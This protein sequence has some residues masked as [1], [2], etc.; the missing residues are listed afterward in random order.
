MKKQW[1]IPAVFALGLLGAACGG[2]GGGGSATANP[3]ASPAGEAA[4]GG[5]ASLSIQGFAFHPDTL[6]A[7]AGASLTISVTNNDTTTHS[8]TLDDGSVSKDVPAGQTVQVKVTFPQSG[9]LGWHCR[10]HP[11]MTGTLKV[12]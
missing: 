12:G 6:T 8:V 9:T 11:T 5:T 10:F 4:G 1:I 3:T 2:G 7:A